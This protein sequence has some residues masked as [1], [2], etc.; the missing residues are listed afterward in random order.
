M[1][2]SISPNIVILPMGV[3]GLPLILL[4]PLVLA[5]LGGWFSVRWLLGNTIS[6]AA[7]TGEKPNIDL[8][9]MGARWAPADPFVHWRLGV[10]AQREFTANNLDETEIGRA[11]C[12]ERV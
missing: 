2:R 3:L 8:A 4:V 10:M 5:F 1:P 9:R 7:S 11:S 12:R 6:E